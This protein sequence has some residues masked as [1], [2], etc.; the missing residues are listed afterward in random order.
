MNR[1]GFRPIKGGK[2]TYWID[3]LKNDE[4]ILTKMQPQVRNKI[5]KVKD[6]VLL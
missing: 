2:H 1:A 3:L 6:Q 4:D 5:R